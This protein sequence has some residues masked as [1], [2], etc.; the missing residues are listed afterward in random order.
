MRRYLL[1][2]LGTALLA[3]Y[4]G[5]LDLGALFERARSF[6]PPVALLVVLLNGACGAVKTLRW[7][8]FLSRAGIDVPFGRSFLSVHAAFFM[9]LVTPGTAG[10]LA[11]ALSLERGRGRGLAILVF[12]KLCDLGALAALAGLTVVG[13]TGGPR[14]LLATAAGLALAAAAGY[15][16]WTR[17]GASL[18]RPL[19]RVLGTI[20]AAAG[21]DAAARVHDQFHALLSSPRAVAASTAYSVALWLLST[22]QVALIYGG[23]GLK[24]SW[25]FVALSYFLPYLV[26]VVSLVPL[27]LGTFEMSLKQLAV[28]ASEGVPAEVGSL[29]PAFFRAFV[30]VP[31]VIFGYG[32]QAATALGRR[33]GGAR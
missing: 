22:F 4:F 17:G 29:V 6:P 7:T 13:F 9:G 14:W 31:L 15:L 32:C 26:G 21:G 28:S 2:I 8:R 27:G 1:L 5:R 20:F 3:L 24:P 18:L 10:E 19:N 33:P 11:R 30:T 16:V 12:E 25:G 23:L